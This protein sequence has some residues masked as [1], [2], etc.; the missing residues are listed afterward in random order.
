MTSTEERGVVA[1]Y[2]LLRK[3]IGSIGTLLPI[4]L[5]V[6]DAAF[7]SGPLP[8][9]ISSYYYTPM[10]N[11]LEGALFVLG[12]FL[13]VYDVGVRADRLITNVAGL[14]VLGVALLPGSP[15]IPHLSTTQ[16]VVNDLHVCSASV[17]FVGFS[18]VIWRFSL[19]GSDGPGSPAPSRDA[20]IFHRAASGVMLVFV[21]LSGLS[22][23]L[24]PQVQDAWKPV[25]IFESLASITFGVSWLVKGRGLQPLLSTTAPAQLPP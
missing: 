5:V 10:R 20:A 4:V 13:L 7:T 8:I 1:S 6:G 18:L 2:L 22:I 3:V 14:G 25:F 11:I 24:S 9:D 15:D 12:V 19:A 23:L 21:I 17:A 16:Q